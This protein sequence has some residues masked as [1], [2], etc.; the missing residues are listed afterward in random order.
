MDKCVMKPHKVDAVAVHTINV[1]AFTVL[2]F[3]SVKQNIQKGF[4]EK[5]RFGKTVY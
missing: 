3:K 2:V 5:D 1:S 4:L